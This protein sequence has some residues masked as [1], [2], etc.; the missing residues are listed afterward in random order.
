MLRIL[1]S[2]LTYLLVFDS[3]RD[4]IQQINF[5]IEEQFTAKVWEEEEG[6]L[7]RNV[8]RI[9][10]TQLT[11]LP[12]SKMEFLC[13]AR[14]LFCIRDKRRGAPRRINRKES[15]PDQ[16]HCGLCCND[17]NKYLDEID[18]LRSEEVV[19]G[20]KDEEL[21]EDDDYTDSTMGNCKSSNHS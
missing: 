20:I 17:L 15:V 13:L 1:D 11:G 6:K 21:E 7:V 9:R 4:C 10:L 16:A 19:R 5:I 8:I 12:A 14:S 18:I 3:L 2:L